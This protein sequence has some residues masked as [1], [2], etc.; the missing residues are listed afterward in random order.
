MA[1]ILLHTPTSTP[2]LNLALRFSVCNYLIKQS[3]IIYYRNRHHVSTI[4]TNKVPL[5]HRA[6]RIANNAKTCLPWYCTLQTWKQVAFWN[7][8]TLKTYK[9]FFGPV[10]AVS[11][12]IVC[13]VS[14]SVPWDVSDFLLKA[15]LPIMLDACH[16]CMSPLGYIPWKTF[17]AIVHIYLGILGAYYADLLE[18]TP[19]PPILILL[20]L[21]CFDFRSCD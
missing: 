4:K 8:K 19:S 7:M 12:W 10:R 14:E 11:H 15:L 18:Y 16:I 5:Q 13:S 3:F 21:I 2:M 20:L 17:S 9:S 6:T 1:S